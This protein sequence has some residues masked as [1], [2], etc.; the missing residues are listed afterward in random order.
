MFTSVNFLKNNI[1]W[2][3]AIMRAFFSS[4]VVGLI[5]HQ[6]YVTISYLH[7]INFQYTLLHV[8][9]NLFLNT[10]HVKLKSSKKNDRNMKNNKQK[11]HLV[12]VMGVPYRLSF[13]CWLQVAYMPR[14]S[15]Y[16][17]ALRLGLG[18]GLLHFAK[19]C[20]CNKSYTW[21]MH[22]LITSVSWTFSQTWNGSFL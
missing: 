18:F 9:T 19:C 17:D 4:P 16:Q 21:I 1:P 3:G 12:E 11:V 10:W 13:P 7:C 5:G 15:S 8:L 22:V 20:N 2:L 6:L 14:R